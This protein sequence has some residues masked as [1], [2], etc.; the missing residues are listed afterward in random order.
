MDR[1]VF[2]S[3]LERGLA[4]AARSASGEW[5]VEVLFQDQQLLCL[6]ADPLNPDI[7]YAGTRGNGVLRRTIAAIPGACRLE[8]T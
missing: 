6:A 8:S 7:V 4:R 1:T 2:L 5:P 3:T